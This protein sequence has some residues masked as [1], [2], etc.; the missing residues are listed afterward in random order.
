MHSRKETTV[1]RKSRPIATLTTVLLL[2]LLAAGAQE[3]PDR[4]EPMDV[5]RVQVASDPQ[6]SPDG[7]RIVYSRKVHE[8]SENNL[9]RLGAASGRS[10]RSRPANHPERSA[11]DE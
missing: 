5:F 8:G 9:V 2:R 3:L 1:F 11:H 4:L 6:I 7:K 10:F